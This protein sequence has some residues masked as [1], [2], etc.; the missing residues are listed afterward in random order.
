MAWDGLPVE[1]DGGVTVGA[2][3]TGGVTGAGVGTGTTGAGVGVTEGVA[4]PPEVDWTGTAIVST[5]IEAAPD[6]GVEESAKTWVDAI[7]KQATLSGMVL[8]KQNNRELESFFITIGFQRFWM[9][10]LAINGANA[11]LSG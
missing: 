8:A 7:R 11:S 3:G 2:T 9:K 1:G 4:V 6:E 10:R 5:V